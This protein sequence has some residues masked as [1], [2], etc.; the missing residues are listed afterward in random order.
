VPSPSTGDAST[1]VV[2]SDSGLTTTSATP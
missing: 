2:T 1:I